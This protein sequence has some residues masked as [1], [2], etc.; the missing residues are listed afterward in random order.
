MQC[1]A[2]GGKRMLCISYGRT[3][4][5]QIDEIVR[6]KLASALKFYKTWK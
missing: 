4:N 6:K 5:F 1:K 3:G 2:N